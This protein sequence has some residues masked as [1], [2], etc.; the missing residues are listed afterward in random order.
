MTTLIYDAGPK[1]K[2]FFSFAIKDISGIIS[3]IGPDSVD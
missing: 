1:K 2:E 3:E